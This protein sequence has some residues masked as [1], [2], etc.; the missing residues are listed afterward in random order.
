MPAVVTQSG[1]NLM[2]ARFAAG[3]AVVIDTV[4]VGTL[5]AGANYDA[6]V[7]ASALRAASGSQ[8]HL[9]TRA[10][11]T[12][13][14]N[15]GSVQ[16]DVTDTGAGIYDADEIGYFSGNTLVFLAAE[17]AGPYFVKA[18]GAAVIFSLTMQLGATAATSVTLTVPAVQFA[19]PAEARALTANNRSMSPAR[20]RDA[21]LTW[22]PCLERC[23]VASN[24]AS[25]VTIT[26][27]ATHTVLSGVGATGTATLGDIA[28]RTANSAN[29]DNGSELPYLILDDIPSGALT[30][31][32]YA[33]TKGEFLL[34]LGT[35]V[36]AGPMYLQDNGQVTRAYT[37]R[38][39]GFAQVAVGGNWLC[40]I[41]MH[42]W[43][44]SQRQDPVTQTFTASGTWNKPAGFR[45]GVVEAWGGGASGASNASGGGGAYNRWE[46]DDG[47]VGAS[48]AVTVGA[49][50]AST[51]GSGVRNAGGDSVFGAAP[52]VYMTAPGGNRGYRDGSFVD[53]GAGHG[54][55]GTLWNPMWAGGGT[56]RDADSV[57]GGGAGSGTAFGQRGTDFGHSLYGGNGGTGGDLQ[58]HPDNGGDGVA[59]GGGG[60]QQAG[61]GAS[62]AGARG[63]VRVTSYF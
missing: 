39:V 27:P 17:A 57:Y 33:Y 24:G 34:N 42:S 15:Q 43:K 5:A 28:L 21:L 58:A 9:A 56:G 52:N 23:E 35:G 49:G 2:A 11:I 7:T 46:F 45:R 1:L 8:R 19:S 3:Q 40:Y 30:R 20:T 53:I 63:E 48:V 54:G 26:S 31:G 32:Y 4:T 59:P 12:L 51:T 38:P 6:T 25:A 22:Y 13:L 61:A 14:A 50:G 18:G 60:G 44:F 36:T 62:G 29:W 55:G 47:D 16:L 37:Y 41:D 10:D